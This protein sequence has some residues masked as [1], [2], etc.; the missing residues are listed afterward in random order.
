MN[1]K[2]IASLLAHAKKTVA[3]AESCTGG[4]IAHTLTNISGSSG[5]FAAGFVAYSNRAKSCF[6]KIPPKTIARFGAVSKQVAR[7]MAKNV[8]S[9][10]GT[11]IG[12]AVT[13]IAGPS[14]GSARKPVGTVYVALA[15]AD[16]T[17]V[18]RFL[19]RGARVDIKK[20]TAGAALL[21]LK[22]CLTTPYGHSSH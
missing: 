1:A 6:L 2:E 20:K 9:L 17:V 11:D 8:R 19:F 12:L 3:V 16:S 10:A 5:Y 15:D 21:L 18:K 14:G 13:G 22:K 4:L 7:A